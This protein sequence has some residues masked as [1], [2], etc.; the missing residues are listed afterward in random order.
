MGGRLFVAA[1][2]GHE[3][4]DGL[5]GALVAVEDGVHLLGDWHFD[6]VASGEAQSG[7]GAADTFGYL[8]VEAGDDVRKLP[9]TAELDADGAVA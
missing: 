9:A 2:T 4:T 6:C 1:G 8:A 7:C 3:L 5:F